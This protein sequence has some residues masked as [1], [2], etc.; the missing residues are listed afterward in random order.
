MHYLII[1]K[2]KKQ[3]IKLKNKLLE[4]GFDVG[5]F[6]YADCCKIKKFSKF[7]NNKSLQSLT[8]NLITL[9]THKRITKEYAEKLSL[10]ILELY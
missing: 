1:A 2:S 4:S 9:P 6:F 7:G 3:I 8:D 5:S 10:K